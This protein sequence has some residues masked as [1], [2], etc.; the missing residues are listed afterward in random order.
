[1]AAPEIWVHLRT[2]VWILQNHA[3]PHAGLFSQ[4]DS[5]P[6]R[7]STWGFD[8]LLG[9][10]YRLFDL[11]AIPIL[12]IVLKAAMAVVT[13]LLARAGRA[14][15]W[16]AA[17]LSA[18]AQIV[19]SN[20]QPLPYVFSILFFA[21]ELAL[22][23]R[24]RRIG[25]VR[26]LFWLP[27]LFV[28]WANLNV[29]FVA[30]LI[31]LAIFL[32]AVAVEDGLRSTGFRW[33]SLQIIPL[34]L[35][36][37]S[38]V[39]GL[40]LCGAL[41]NPYGFRIVPQ[42][43]MA[44]Y[45]PVGF[46]H[47]TEMKSMGFRHPQEFVL[48]L[49][50]MAAFLALGRRR[51]VE[52]FELLTLLAGTLVAFRISREGWLA[53]LPAVAALS[54]GLGLGTPQDQADQSAPSRQEWWGAA[55]LTAA[56]LMIAIVIVPRPQTLMQRASVGSP[57]KACDFIRE[58]QLPRPIFNEYSWGSFLTWYLPEYP[59]VVDSRGELYGNEI[60][61]NYF[62]IVSGKELL[63][64]QPMVAR[65]GTLLLEKESAIAKALINLPGLRAQ[66]D[67]VYSDDISSVYIKRQQNP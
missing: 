16:T 32:A 23:V 4:Y 25:N 15:L 43:W 57:V 12:L 39:L 34:E 2:G 60:L 38:V 8:L 56:A 7:D 28:V 44:L 13:F 65:A 18:I 36:A 59:V 63:E 3:I 10:A 24:S 58:K 45:S 53:V 19:I 26:I 30:G 55:A 29:Q 5:L 64:S 40:S 37:V 62:T 48:M 21:A 52:V 14:N 31:L 11:R 22:L 50:V 33:L 61:D 49:L 20:L 66:Y 41:I 35:K 17:L 6:W 1:M 46:E 47:F 54:G 51:S 67:L 27:P 42:A 9:T